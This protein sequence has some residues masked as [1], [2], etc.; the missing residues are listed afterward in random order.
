VDRIY[1][2]DDKCPEQTGHYVQSAN[3]DPRLRVLFNERNRG[4]GGAMIAGYQAAIQDKADII[5]KVDGDGQ[6]NPT[7]IPL[8]AEP[9]LSGR[10]DYVKGNRFYLLE[11]LK[12]MPTVRLFGNM[13][14]SFINKLV[15][16]YWDLMDP[17]NGY[18]AIHA[19]VAAALPLNKVSKRYFFESDMLFRLNT[20]R[21][22]IQ[23]VPMRA[24]YGEEK[25]NLNI[26]RV[27]IS[28]PGKY[29]NRLFKRIV[30]NYYLRDF[31]F[32]SLML[33]LGIVL[34]FSGFAFGTYYLI[35]N[36][37]SG[38]AASSGIVMMA[39][40]PI[41]LGF[42]SLIYFFQHDISSVPKDSIHEEL[43]LITKLKGTQNVSR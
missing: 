28:F 38:V 22:V 7:L 34:S 25:S 2:V 31:N 13:A 18:T 19:A 14:L 29:M 10:A 39:A 42:Q 36:R 33:I 41:I 15:S 30:Y 9:I 16:G 8:F 37:H 27:L 11:D 26:S 20:I 17:T 1:L 21:A 23:D 43:A 3:S 24:R 32:G 6:M 40:L 4:V 35:H 12:D 5:V